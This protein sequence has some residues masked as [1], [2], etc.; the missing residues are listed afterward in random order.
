MPA[1]CDPTSTAPGP[2]SPTSARGSTASRSR[3]SSR[4]RGVAR[5]HPAEIAARLDD[6]YRLLRGGRGAERHRTLQ[7]AVGWSY[8]LLDPDEQDVFDR[9]SVFAGGALL[10]ALARVCGRDEY[11]TLDVVDRLVARSMV[12]AEQ[13]ALGTRYRQLETLRQYGEDRLAERDAIEAARSADL[14][15]IVEL[16][17][18]IRAR[19]YTPAG[20]EAF[21]RYVGELDNLR[22]AVAYAVEE[23]RDDV[24]GS[25]VACLG[26]FP[27]VHG[28]HELADWWDPIPRDGMWTS[29]A[30]EAAAVIA[31]VAFG[32]G[33]SDE[34]RTLMSKVPS[35]FDVI[36]LVGWVRFSC[37]LVVDGDLAAA[38]AL[39]S[40]AGADHDPSRVD[41]YLDL[42]RAWLATM[43]LYADPSEDRG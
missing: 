31:L 10:D 5:C 1:P 30:A 8:D 2:R 14:D 28:T 21:R 13:T 12:I 16:T 11:D 17:A 38:A 33:R 7:A 35:S 9:M 19:R 40:A 29:E 15:W 42:Q 3:S 37:A 6:R 41:N 34:M 27:H 26:T 23:G 4:P 43:E 25:A 22:V 36:P 32:A 20:G 24:V 39:T 18:S